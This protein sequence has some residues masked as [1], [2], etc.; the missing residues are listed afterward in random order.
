V[1]RDD[2]NREHLLIVADAIGDPA[3]KLCSSAEVSQ[4]CSFV[5]MVQTLHEPRI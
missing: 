1:R 5:A 2:P 4:A 3:A